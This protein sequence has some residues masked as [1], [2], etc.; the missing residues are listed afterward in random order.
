V[1]VRSLV[2]TLGIIAFTSVPAFAADSVDSTL[3]FSGWIDS[4]FSVTDDDSDDV[5]GTARDEE[6]MTVGF[7]ALASLKAEVHVTESLHGK[8]NLWIGPDFDLLDARELYLTYAFNDEWS[9]TG[10]KYINHLGW[11]G[12]EPTSLFRVNNS[13][14]GYYSNYGNDVIGSALSFAPKDSQFSGSFHLVNGYFTATDAG[15]RSDMVSLGNGDTSTGPSTSRENTGLGFGLD[16]V[17]TPD[18]KININAEVA[19]DIDSDAFVDVAGTGLVASPTGTQ[20]G[21]DVVFLGLNAT[22][23]TIDR[24]TLGAE[25]IS[26]MVD[27]NENAT[28]GSVSDSDTSIL[29]GLLAA[30]YAF[31][32]DSTPCP[33]SV[34]VMVQHVEG[35]Q[36]ELEADANEVS[37][38]LLTNPLDVSNFGLNFEI[39]WSK[40]EVDDGATTTDSKNIGFF[41]EGLLTF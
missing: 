1:S 32:P 24:L 6:S 41:V 15:N 17:F 16:L 2:P 25:I 19:Y 10:G 9:L 35:E 4:I 37:A 21:G 14:I 18:E 20:L 30:N 5:V 28:G 3:K 31:A 29:Q 11:V 40:V 33:M 22:L 8:M 39:A 13:T 34:T 12:A 23:K 38:A 27:E 36:D 26:I 7:N